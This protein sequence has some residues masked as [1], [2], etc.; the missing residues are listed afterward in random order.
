MIGPFGLARRLHGT[1]WLGWINTGFFA[2][3]TQAMRRNSL[4]LRECFR[5]TLFVIT[6]GK[7][8]IT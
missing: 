2:Q 3:V 8:V 6:P 5:K 4:E 1:G 7:S